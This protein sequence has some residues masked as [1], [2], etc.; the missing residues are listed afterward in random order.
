MEL[1]KEQLKIIADKSNELDLGQLDKDIIC[2]A[3][4]CSVFDNI[5]EVYVVKALQKAYDSVKPGYNDCSG[6]TDARTWSIIMAQALKE[7]LENTRTEN[8]KMIDSWIAA[9]I[10]T[11]T[12]D[13]NIKII[14]SEYPRFRK[15]NMA[16]V[17]N[18]IETIYLEIVPEEQYDPYIWTTITEGALAMLEPNKGKLF[19]IEFK[20]FGAYV[21]ELTVG[22]AWIINNLD[23]AIEKICFKMAVNNTIDTCIDFDDD[24]SV[25]CIITR[26]S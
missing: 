26:I 16:D 10:Q 21:K 9:N 5:Y 8:Q 6:R 17:L 20:D 25:P 14:L 11:G 24:E 19:K 1:T 15:F 4:C 3:A 18:A 13:K 22:S 7:L 23:K 2:D 12:L